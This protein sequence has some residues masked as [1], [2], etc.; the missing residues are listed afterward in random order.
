MDK[1]IET[2]VSLDCKAVTV[3]IHSISPTM[4][5]SKSIMENLMEKAME[6]G[7]FRRIWGQGR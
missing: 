1:E 7:V 5:P 4:I 6:T 2:I 3:E